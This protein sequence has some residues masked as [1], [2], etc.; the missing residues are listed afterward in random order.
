[1]PWHLMVHPSMPGG[2]SASRPFG[3][4]REGSKKAG[5]LA[6]QGAKAARRLSGNSASW[7]AAPGS[8]F[9]YF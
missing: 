4:K 1:M 6:G 5:E 3:R 7:M 9:Q 8:H 2:D